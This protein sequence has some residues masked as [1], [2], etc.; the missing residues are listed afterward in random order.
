MKTIGLHNEPA[1]DCR[2][3]SVL[4]PAAFL[5]RAG[6]IIMLSRAASWAIGAGAV[7]C[8]L[9]FVPAVHANHQG[10]LSHSDG[11]AHTAVGAGHSI[12]GVSFQI[13]LGSGNDTAAETGLTQADRSAALETVREAFAVL[14]QHRNDYPRFDESLKKE[15]L[16]R[17]V[18]ETT[19]VNDEGR[20][21]PFLVAR[22]A[23]PGRVTLLISASSL[24]E[25]GYLH[26][27][28]TLAPV[29]A[30]EFQWVASKADTAPKPKMVAG[31]RALKSAPIRTD[32]D[33]AA[34]SGEERVRL[35]QQLLGSYL[36]T[37]DDQRSLDGQSYYEVG[38]TALVAPTHPD[39][40]TK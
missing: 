4:R 23:Q 39:S 13:F 35:L 6:R 9:L 15:A 19:V 29:L 26:H 27:P 31:E 14:L 36:R 20:A 25:N 17:V 28:D 21:F 16:A 34:L 33:I 7:A 8:A 32:Q 18:I 38:S 11:E 12:P 24:K 3:V 1:L 5:L 37:V 2:Q 22:T 40:T 30:R 10:H